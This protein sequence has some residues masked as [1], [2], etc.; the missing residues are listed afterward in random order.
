MDSDSDSVQGV[1]R[2]R[3]FR[4]GGLAAAGVAAGVPLVGAG[5]GANWSV[6]PY[7]GWVAVTLINRDSDSLVDIIERQTQA[8]TGV[9]PSGGAG[10]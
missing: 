5:V 3:L 6:Y 4:W 8:V 9:A 2:R 7:T 1:G 10:G